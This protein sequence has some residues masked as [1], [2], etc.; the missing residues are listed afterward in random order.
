MGTTKNQNRLERWTQS[1]ATTIV[2]NK[3][4][5]L[6]FTAIIVGIAGAGL[7][8]LN[9]NADSKVFFSKEN[10]QLMAYEKIE[11]VY[12]DDDNI[13]IA[14]TEKN[15]QIFSN[16]TLGAIK[17]LVDSA[18]QTPYSFRVDAITN[19]QY[20]RSEGDNLVVSDL[21]EDPQVLDKTALEKIK[22]IAL[23]EP[24]LQNRL[25][26]KDATVTGINISCKIPNEN[27]A[28]PEVVSYIRKMTADWQQE[29]PTMEVHLS[30][31]VMLENAF[32][33]TAQKDGQ[34]LVPLVFGIFLV[35]IFFSTRSVSSTISSFLVVI[36]SILCALGTAAWLGIDLTSAS[37]NAPIVISTLAISDCIHITISFLML[38][39]EGK[40]KD[41]AIIESIRINFLPVIITSVTTIIGFLSL[42]TGDV[43]PYAD[44][45]NISAI[46]M[47]FALLFSLITLPALLAIFPIKVKQKASGTKVT[48]SRYDKYVD[49]IFKNKNPILYASIAITL[50]GSYFTV[51]NQLN[52]EF[53]KYFNESIQFRK[54]T[55]YINKNLTGIYNLEFSIPAN[56][57]GNI[58]DPSYLERLEAFTNY[59]KAQPEV[60]HVNSFTEV[61]KRVN[62]AMHGD[63]TDFYKNPDNIEEAAQYLLLY[64]LSLPYG[65]DLNNQVNNGK[66]ETRFTVTLREIQSR[67]MIDFSERL[68]TWLTNNTPAHMVADGSSLSLMF[69]HIGERQVS[70]LINGAILSA[71]LITIVLMI[72]FKSIKFGA[73]SIVSNVMPALIGFGIWYF[74]LG[75]VNLGM[76]AVFGMTLGI[77]V[78]NSIHFISKYLR[79][80]KENALTS[81]DA[82]RYAFNK[83]GTAILATTS[84]LCIGFFVLTQSAFLIN[85]S[86]AL[87][88]I[89]ILLA[90]VLVCFST[91]PILLEKMDHFTLNIKNKK[92]MKTSMTTTLLCLFFMTGLSFT[93]QGQNKGLEIAQKAKNADLGF[94]NYEVETKMV[95]TNKNGQTTTNLLTSKAVEVKG[96]GEKSL[97]NFNS[98]KDVSG[99]KTLTYTHRKGE[100]DQ[101][102]Y[103]PA[104][105]RVKRL[106]SSNKSGPF[107]GSEFAFE[108]L[109][110]FEVEKFDYKFIKEETMNGSKIAMVELTPK[111]TKSGYSKKIV[112]YNLDKTYRVEK[113]EFFD[114]KGSPLKTLT[115]EGYKLYEQ[116]YWRA[117]K[118][119]MV[120]LQNGKRTELFF[121]K[122][123]FKTALT[124][125]SMTEENLKN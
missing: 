29:H 86:L 57:D 96:D 23:A 79:A 118:L 70:S 53:I 5:S 94:V 121:T 43:P 27:T 31:N 80:K 74:I 77:I 35:M 46:G 73:L 8:K 122:Y 78:D 33:E 55:D 90:S 24:L 123:K 10:P 109:T 108:D 47:G 110:S 82:I 81:R 115:Y 39:K 40:R 34:T 17:I 11:Q 60:V 69:A 9:F 105:A 106:T 104:V 56:G 44:F 49:F 61:P 76:T 72:T 125:A 119:A 65:L 22:Q 13:L 28:T 18:W 87:I 83:V 89:I 112:Y 41:E 21:V 93:T 62:K 38:L 51:K 45:G 42:N 50:L 98:P 102:I 67:Q 75:Y 92:T 107:M 16:E 64:E 101:W 97:I 68:K 52:D 111:D 15:G 91:L 26:N 2:K 85:S 7:G 48:I 12:S 36:I 66:S 84:I 114:R 95:L 117:D 113:I 37:S 71:V 14:I 19:F 88:T 20:T 1:F 32:S 3:W 30:G 25:I 124:E 4:W 63:S 116:K 100:D 54:D 103:L 99:T 120:N 6:L 59:V 58:N